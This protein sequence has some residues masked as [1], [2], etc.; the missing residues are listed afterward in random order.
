VARR[1]PVP[2]RDRAPA[3]HRPLTTPPAS[4]GGRSPSARR[5]R[6]AIPC[7]RHSLEAL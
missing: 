2:Q 6:Q 3:A 1:R 7:G 4:L 5:R